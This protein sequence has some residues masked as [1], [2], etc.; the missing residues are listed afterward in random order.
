MRAIQVSRFGGPEVLEIVDLPDPEPGEGEL[1]IEVSG[2]GV[3]FAD[4]HQIENT[5]LVTR[6]LPFV[7]GSEAVGRVLSGPRAGERVCGFV[8]REGGYRQRAL[9][10]E[11]RSFVVPDEVSDTAAL[12]LLI[13]GMTAWH[14]LRT[15]ARL[16]PGESILINAAAGGVGS[17]AVQLA[18]RWG[19]G[20]IIANASTPEKLAVAASL[21][22]DIGI[23]LRNEDS[24][25]HIAE[26]IRSANNGNDV[27]IVLDMVG[28]PVFDG[29][30]DA[31]ARG[32]RMVTYGNAARLPS[33]PVAP[34]ALL[35]RGQ[36]LI[37][38]MVSDAVRAASRRPDGVDALSDLVG[39][40]QRGE[41]V[42]LE[43]H[44]YPLD[45]APAAFEAMRAR[46]TT[47][48]V[49]LVP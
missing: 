24:A 31:V 40:V 46:S 18:R 20:R 29:C 33:T 9:V 44:S 6:D 25:E 2:A 3:N 47:G 1:L 26:Q 12:S 5:Y 28:G 7:P 36:S 32:G 48:K 45:E 27:D 38:F 11:A 22:A 15:G 37:G 14:L 42:P 16:M 19:A 34:R 41:L 4:T 43:G 30:L 10:A 8:A 35:R 23:S 49:V 39:M 17:L 21:G 13:Q